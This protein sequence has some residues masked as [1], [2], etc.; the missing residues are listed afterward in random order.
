MNEKQVIQDLRKQPKPWIGVIPQ[1]TFSST[2]T[3][4]EAGLL[5][6]RTLEN[7]FTKMGYKKQGKK[8]IKI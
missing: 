4:Y 3:R 5:K 2:I 7:F 8:W 1:S 6:P